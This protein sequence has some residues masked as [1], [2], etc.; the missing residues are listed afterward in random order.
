METNNA[1]E[2]SKQGPRAFS[3]LGKGPGTYWFNPCQLSSQSYQHAAAGRGWPETPGRT[4]ER[5]KSLT[6]LHRRR[7][8]RGSLARWPRQP[9]RPLESVTDNHP[10][11]VNYFRGRRARGGKLFP[12]TQISGAGS[13]AV[14]VVASPGAT[15]TPSASATAVAARRKPPRTPVGREGKAPQLGRRHLPRVPRPRR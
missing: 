8:S 6:S 13:A 14:L 11:V 4:D 15:A 10:E 12:R 5:G 3:R 9:W 2:D 1:S 7:V